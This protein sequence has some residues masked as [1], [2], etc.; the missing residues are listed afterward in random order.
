[1]PVAVIAEARR[2]TQMILPGALTGEATVVNAETVR[3]SAVSS[4]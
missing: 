2:R 1:M 3:E 4:L